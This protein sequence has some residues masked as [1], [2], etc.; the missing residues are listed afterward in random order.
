MT[1][2]DL[3][4]AARR[5]AASAY[6]SAE[7]DTS[8]LVAG[9]RATLT[10]ARHHF[11]WLRLEM[12]TPA[13]ASIADVRATGPLHALA[14]SLGAGGDLLASQNG[15][16]CVALEDERSLVAARSEVASITALGARAALTR[17]TSQRFCG[18]ESTS[19]LFRHLVEIIA[20][21][22]FLRRHGSADIGTLG[23]LSTTLPIT[24]ANTPSQVVRLAARWQSAHEATSAVGVLTRD[25]RSSTA[26]LRTV[27]GY[28]AHLVGVLRAAAGQSE[29]LRELAHALRAADGAASRVA[30]AWRT[31]LSDLNG[32]SDAPA[33]PL[34]AELLVA[35]RNWLRDGKRLR[36]PEDV[37]TDEQAAALVREV[38]D[39]LMRAAHRVASVQQETVTWLVMRGELFV[40]RAELAKR[41]PEYEFRSSVWRL[42]YPQRHWVRTNRSSCFDELTST[43]AEL[44]DQLS[45]AADVAQRIAGTATLRRPFGSDRVTAPPVAKRSRWRWYEPASTDLVPEIYLDPTGPER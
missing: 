15:S 21:L 33:E 28:A 35:L 45:V 13:F 8:D 9:W 39:E 40:P 18:A 14:Q 19:P 5:D 27:V 11:K 3:L 23:G 29:D 12:S 32:R 10:A 38:V 30:H 6:N 2:E 25:L 41:D 43:L 16:T 36:E 24:P 31:R 20:E 42:R 7:A 17:L 26:Q 34:F 4:W 1:Y 22:E 44:T 37:V